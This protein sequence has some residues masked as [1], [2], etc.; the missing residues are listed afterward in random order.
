MP[1]VIVTGHVQFTKHR[2]SGSIRI[3][4]GASEQEIVCSS[5][6][7]QYDDVVAKNGEVRE[8]A[9]DVQAQSRNIVSIEESRKSLMITVEHTVFLQRLRPKV[10][11]HIIWGDL[12][13]ITEDR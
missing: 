5:V 2:Q 8:V 6:R 7:V 1:G 13:H 3:D 4:S 10:F 11:P 9:F 12:K